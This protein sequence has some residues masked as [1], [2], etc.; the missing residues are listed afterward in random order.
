MP[1][2]CSLLPALRLIVTAQTLTEPGGRS[3]CDLFCDSAGLVPDPSRCF[4]HLNP[5]TL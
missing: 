3:R 5:G 1:K 4:L 2:P